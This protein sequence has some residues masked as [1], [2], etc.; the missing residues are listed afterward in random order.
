M[1]DDDERLEPITDALRAKLRAERDRTGITA[2]KLLKASRDRPE[3]LDARSVNRWIGGLIRSAPESHI[4]YVLARWAELPDHP[5]RSAHDGGRRGRLG[6]RHAKT[7]EMWIEVTDEMRNRLR[8]ELERT[9]SI[10]SRLLDGQDNLPHGLNRR[11]VNGWLY[12]EIGKA[13]AARWRF[14]I[15]LLQDRPDKS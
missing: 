4:A 9:G 6:R 8:R 11:V 13:D 2:I 3:G 7:G 15:A 10:V 5:V 1:T 12:G 14:V